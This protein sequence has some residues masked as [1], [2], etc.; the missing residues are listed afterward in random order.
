MIK[1][2]KYIY[3]YRHCYYCYYYSVLLSV[4]HKTVLVLGSKNEKN[5]TGGNKR[6]SRPLYLYYAVTGYIRP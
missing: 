6:Y 4:T 3:T 2:K 1:K 5:I